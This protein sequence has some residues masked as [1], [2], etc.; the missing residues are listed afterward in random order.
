MKTHSDKKSF[1]I[2]SVRKPAS[3]NKPL[4]SFVQAVREESSVKQVLN[5]SVS[6][7]EGKKNLTLNQ[8]LIHLERKVAFFN[9]AIREITDLVG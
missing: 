4:S 3:D 5:K 6:H 2:T 7:K 9:F 1:S 8:N